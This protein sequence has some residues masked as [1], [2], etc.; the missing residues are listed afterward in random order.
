MSFLQRLSARP[1]ASLFATA[2]KASSSISRFTPAQ[3]YYSDKGK[4]PASQLFDDLDDEVE[5]TKPFEEV[6][7]DAPTKPSN[8]STS[9]KGIQ[10]DS[11]PEPYLAHRATMKRKFP[12]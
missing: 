2:S 8:L 5:F 11:I 4:A 10:R 1:F 6:L 9:Q 3:R 7:P 12:E